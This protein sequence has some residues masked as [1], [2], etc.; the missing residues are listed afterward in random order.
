MSW[1]RYYRKTLSRRSMLRGLGASAGGLFLTPFLGQ[2]RAE[3]QGLP[4]RQKLIFVVKGN[5]FSRT[6]SRRGL[7]ST[8]QESS[9][10]SNW[11]EAMPHAFSWEPWADRVAYLDG[12]ANKMGPGQGAGHR[13]HY[14]ALISRPYRG[15]GG[16]G[17]ISIDEYLGQRVGGNSV[18]PVLRL[19]SEGPGRG[20]DSGSSAAGAG[21]PL[22]VQN[23]PVAA[24]RELFGVAADDPD[25][26]AAFEEKGLVM[27]ALRQQARAAS[28]RLNGEDRWKLERYLF[29][30]ETFQTQHQQLS[31]LGEYL[32]TCAPPPPNVGDAEDLG[33]LFEKQANVAAGAL[34]CGL[35]DIVVL[36][37]GNKEPFAQY[38]S[39]GFGPA[40]T[41]GHGKG[42][43]GSRPGG[44]A[45]LALT[46]G[47]INKRV[48]DLILGP[49][50]AS[51][52]KS[53]AEF[54][55]NTTV[56]HLNDNGEAH[57]SKYDLWPVIIAG[58]FGGR[59]RTGGRAIQYPDP[60]RHEG[61]GSLNQLWNTVAHGMGAPTDDF[62][63]DS[64]IPKNKRGTLSEL[65]L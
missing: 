62:A 8:V 23:D 30:I 64:A 47:E 60:G 56:I 41:M 58:D 50:A 11:L 57:H 63:V 20:L 55:D 44:V 34:I 3:A 22:P 39:W 38:L 36:T 9:I 7:G 24:Y 10:G 42:E 28:Q 1:N 6:V 33:T 61:Y 14:Y 27:D 52:G 46:A 4:A 12:L 48:G 54:P 18:F 29:S 32:G 31:Q 13:S 16:P 65:A 17:G 43:T 21:T 53:P 40:H 49:L 26:R 37:V 15:S 59:I 2:L 25:L 5:G 35:T 19:G 51:Q 45:G